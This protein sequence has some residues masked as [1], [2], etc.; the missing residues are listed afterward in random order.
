[1][2]KIIAPILNF[3]KEIIEPIEFSEDFVIRQITEIEL[4]SLKKF[5]EDGRIWGDFVYGNDTQ[6]IESCLDLPPS[7]PNSM[8][9]CR[10]ILESRLAFLR[11]MKP[12]QVAANIFALEEG[13]LEEGVSIKAVLIYYYIP[14]QYRGSPHIYN[15]SGSEIKKIIEEYKSFGARVSLEDNIALRYFFNS[16]HQPLV[17]DRLVDL[18]IALESLY[19]SEEKDRITLRYKLA[20]RCA[21]YIEEQYNERKIVFGDIKRA[22]DIRNRIVH[23]GKELSNESM[24]LF[25]KLED[26]LRKSFLKLFKEKI[27]PKGEDFDRL[28]LE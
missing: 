21:A 12:G 10:K 26:Y 14:W 13:V 4:A 25:P 17:A 7:H 8:D 27:W 22:Y 1:M 6:V 20:M 5:H 11:L 28:L 3:T 18:V 2:L 24:E 19:L 15:L 23:G 16:Y 9:Q